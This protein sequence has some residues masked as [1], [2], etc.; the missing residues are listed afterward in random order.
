MRIY[1][2]NIY[3]QVPRESIDNSANINVFNTVF[4]KSVR[5]CSTAN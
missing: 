3:Q 1:K 4:G 2:Q 5:K